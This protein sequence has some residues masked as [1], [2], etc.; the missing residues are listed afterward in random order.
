MTGNDQLYSFV[1]KGL[2]TEESLDKAGRKNRS[3]IA[4]SDEAIAATL[5]LDLLPSD[6]VANARSMAVIY[7]AVAAFEN[8]VRELISGVLLE[9]YGEGWWEQCVSQN[10]RGRA[11]KRAEE[12]RK[13]KWHTQ[14]GVNPIN[15]TTMAD[16][17][18]VMRNNWDHFEPHVRSIDWVASVFDAVERSRNVIMHS[19]ILEQGDIERLG[20]FLRDWV[21][22]VGA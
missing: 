21:K 16:L 3:E 11:E 13:I 18:N 10:V 8:A 7:T 15:Y 19:G 6:L 17:V 20:V 14:R 5:S 1:L 9:N 22:Q 4:L 2:L 12:E